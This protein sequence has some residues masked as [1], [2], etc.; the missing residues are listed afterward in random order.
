MRI[1]L[2]LALMVLISI[3]AMA[4]SNGYWLRGNDFTTI[5]E[6][7]TSNFLTSN[8]PNASSSSTIFSADEEGSLGNWYSSSFSGGLQ[9]H[10][11][12]TLWSNAIDPSSGSLLWELYEYNQRKATNLLI[13]SAEIAK[14]KEESTVVLE[15]PYNLSQGSRM[16]LV[17]KTE[18]GATLTL[19]KSNL[20]EASEWTSPSNESFQAIAIEKTAL[21]FINQCS[22]DDV[23]CTIDPDC[24][25]NNPFTQ[26]TCNSPATCEASCSYSTCE[27]ACTSGLDCKDENPLTIDVCQNSGTCNA[28]CENIECSPS[29]NSNLEC[30]DSNPNTK[31]FCLH[32]GTCFAECNNQAVEGTAN[33]EGCFLEL[34]LGEECEIITET[35]CCGNNLCEQ[36]ERCETDC[37]GISIE[38]LKPVKGDYMNLEEKFDLV[39]RSERG[40]EPIASGFF[41]SE[42]LYDDGK[43]NDEGVNDGIFGNVFEGTDEAGVKTIV[44]SA[45]GKE[46]HL[47]LNV[48]P[49]L[50]TRIETNK[51]E[52]GLADMLE[53]RGNV[54][55][56]SEP[57]SMEL[58]VNA[59]VGG[60]TIFEGKTESDAFGNFSYPYKSLSLDPAGTWVISILGSDE[61]GNQVNGQTEVKFLVPEELLPLRLELLEPLREEYA[62]NEEIEIK[63][64]AMENNEVVSNAS[65]SAIFPGGKTVEMENQG[66]GLYSLNYLISSGTSGGRVAIVIAGEKGDLT[67]KLMLETRIRQEGIIVDI[68]KPTTKK[69]SL[70]EEIQF[71]ISLALESG[72]IVENPDIKFEINNEEIMPIKSN[73]TY[74]TS[75]LVTEEG[76]IEATIEIEDEFGNKGS[77]LYSA[78]IAGYSVYYYLNHYGLIIL[79][80]LAGLIATIGLLIRHYKKD[81]EGKEIRKREK[82]LLDDIQNIQAR[83]FKQGSLSRRRYD[84]LMLKYEQELENIRKKL[85]VKK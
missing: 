39:V 81:R 71:E 84:E 68:I 25:D 82:A 58:T 34:C 62:R 51:K 11:S 36:G 74:K 41:G 73:G 47:Q 45:E 72:G 32:S 4:A 76:P 63:V 3:G 23:V 42:R 50:E 5:M 21:L 8:P 79:G 33:Q 38:I 59:E 69:F 60:S 56:K 85:G 67:G 48:V 26:D 13:A 12:V 20:Y 43:H 55:R 31:D 40:T 18:D 83:Y 30:N 35:D 9:L 75:Y 61:F 77:A 2:S 15:E 7:K 44:I 52:L 22:F 1:C 70:G 49:L 6:G 46:K 65:I 24:D 53:I 28:G 27:P 54:S 10:T 14:G 17:L 37:L 57:I 78:S 80:V 29:C 66:N 16:K 64:K 19:D